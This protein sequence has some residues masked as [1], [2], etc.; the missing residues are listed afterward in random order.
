MLKQKRGYFIL[1]NEAAFYQKLQT[2]NKLLESEGEEFVAG[3]VE[4]E[5]VGGVFPG[6]L[7]IVGVETELMV[8]VE[9]GNI[10]LLCG[11]LDNLNVS[12]QRLC[13]GTLDRS[14]RGL[15][16]VNVAVAAACGGHKY[17]GLARVVLAQ[18]VHK[19]VNAA[20]EGCGGLV[21]DLSEGS[22]AVDVVIYAAVDNDHISRL[23]HIINS[24]AEAEVVAGLFARVLLMSQTG[25]ADA[26]VIDLR[27][28]AHLLEALIVSAIRAVNNADA[29]GDTVT[30]E[31]YLE[32]FNIHK[33]DP[34]FCDVI[35]IPQ[36]GGIVKG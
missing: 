9:N 30:K 24:A 2:L 4:V 21:A 27:K 19:E 35:I 8:E 34:P 20:A 18:E 23:V 10:E 33:K 26:V 6:D 25:A 31:I 11:L 32:T 17:D 5:A 14:G 29:L 15:E 36:N 12:D 7:G 28:L 3:V 22:V 1:I 13:V 16:V